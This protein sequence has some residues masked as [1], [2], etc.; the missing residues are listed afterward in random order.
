MN[1]RDSVVAALQR[2][3]GHSFADR[4]LLERALTHASAVGSDGA[5][6]Q[7]L[8]FLGD[9][10]LGLVV[11]EMLIDR[12]PDAAEGELARRLTALVRNESC[13]A[14]ALE[15]DLGTAMRLGSGEA[16]SG[17]RKKAAILG[18]VCEAV[19]GALHLDGGIE[20]VRRFI[21]EHWGQRMVA[22][23]GPLRDAKTTLQEW[24][25]GRGLGTPM[26]EI[27][28]RAG[29]D[30]AP[31]FVIE[32]RAP[33]LRPASGSGGNRREAEQNAATAMLRREGAWTDGGPS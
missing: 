16:Q 2:R 7:R 11:A 9:R 14:V 10:V 8:E 25:Q 13:A 22:W 18:D 12:F 17:G 23:T 28:D 33:G 24:A 32:V 4:T 15:L 5:T 26:Y 20:V 21:A 30:H 6:Y 27:V 1:A 3:L 31:R 19:I 29:P